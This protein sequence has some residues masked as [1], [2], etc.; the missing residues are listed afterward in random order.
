[1]QMKAGEHFKKILKKHYP[2]NLEQLKYT[3]HYIIDVTEARSL[4]LFS[5]VQTTSP[6]EGYISITTVELN[7]SSNGATS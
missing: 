1:M 5:V 3:E 7:S 2:V 4:R 6:V